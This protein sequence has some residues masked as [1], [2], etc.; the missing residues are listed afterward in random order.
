MTVAGARGLLPPRK[1]RRERATRA[2]DVLRDISP[3]P[4]RRVRASSAVLSDRLRSEA[5][6][7]VTHRR[8]YDPDGPAHDPDSREVR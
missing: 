6:D 3:D 8:S 1:D 4:L 2:A 7:K 5:R